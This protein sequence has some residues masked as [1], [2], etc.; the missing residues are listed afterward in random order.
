MLHTFLIFRLVCSFWVFFN[1][2]RIHFPKKSKEHFN[3]FCKKK[4]KCFENPES[5]KGF[6]DR[7]TL[8][9]SDKNVQLQNMTIY[10][11]FLFLNFLRWSLA[12]SSMISAYFRL[13]YFWYSASAIN[14]STSDFFFLEPDPR[15][16]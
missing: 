10:F 8:W 12:F 9:I 14:S 11:C 2:F 7:L 1:L 3:F 15:L 6:G 4:K 5:E 13:L 16:E